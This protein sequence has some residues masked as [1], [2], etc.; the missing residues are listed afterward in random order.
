MG[1]ISFVLEVDARHAAAASGWAALGNPA[2]AA[3][4][5]AAGRANRSLSET[6]GV[7]VKNA[8]LAGRA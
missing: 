7:R 3:I 2:T 8:A 6:V 1:V 5:K 4:V